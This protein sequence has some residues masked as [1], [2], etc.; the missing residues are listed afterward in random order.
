MIEAGQIL[1]ISV[2]LDRPD[3]DGA[4]VLA[5]H[6]ALQMLGKAPD[7][8][9]QSVKNFNRRTDVVVIEFKRLRQVCSPSNF[10][11]KYFFEARVDRKSE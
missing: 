6:K 8:M 7:G 2:E 3:L 4:T 9:L 10:F 11:Y 5:R 1:E